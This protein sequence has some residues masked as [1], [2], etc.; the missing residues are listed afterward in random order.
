MHTLRPDLTA[1]D[2]IAA[3]L[4]F[5]SV[6]TKALS[7]HSLLA[8]SSA[9]DV[10]LGL[11]LVLVEAEL[12]LGL[13]LVFRT[14]NAPRIFGALVF[15]IFGCV[16][17][18]LG[19]AGVSSCGCF[20]DVKVNPW[21]TATID[22]VVFGLLAV[23]ATCRPRQ[24]LWNRSRVPA[25][26]SAMLLIGLVVAFSWYRNLPKMSAGSA[27]GG[28]VLLEPNDWFGAPLPIASFCK[29]QLGESEGIVHVLLYHHHCEQCQK[30]IG[31]LA[32]MSREGKDVKLIELPPYGHQVPE[33]GEHFRLEANVEW[34]LEAPVE[35]VLKNG[36]VWK[37]K[38]RDDEDYRLKSIR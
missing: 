7:P 18:S 5:F 8:F 9:Y 12:A 30:A 35:L 31:R 14:G 17:I 3:A 26:I 10:P 38:G 28:L 16:A 32:G 20:G 22:F 4:L 37:V 24:R 1:T 33:V 29:P 11:T 19:V 21:I 6:V 23:A 34:F 2:Y 27:Y 15:L 25:C 13:L 36:L